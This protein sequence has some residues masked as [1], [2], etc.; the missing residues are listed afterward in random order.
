MSSIRIN[1][2]PGGSDN[3]LNVKLDQKFDF[4]EILS[5]KI[6]QEEVYRKFC[7][8]Y[9]VVVG[10]VTV[11]NGF[12]VPNAKVSIF[13]PVDDIDKENSEIFGLYP[14]EQV[15]DKNE[16]AYRYNLLPKKNETNNDCFTPIGSFFNKREVQ[17]N[18]EALEIYCKYYKFTTTTNNSGDFMIFGVPT[19]PNQLHIDAD[20]SN[21]GIISQAP[22]DLIRDGS[23]EKLFQSVS[24]FKESE[25]LDTLTQ[26]KTKSPISVNVIPFWGDLEQCE[27]GITRTDVNLGVNIVPTSI[28]IG[29]IFSD[30]DKGGIN[31]KCVPRGKMGEMDKL[32]TGPGTIE[33]IRKLPDGSTE[34]Y[35]VEGGQV[36]DENGAWA[37][38][39]PMNLDYITTDE[40]GNI[41]PTDDPNRGIPTR[42]RVRFRIGMFD[43]GGEGRLRARAKFLVPHNPANLTEVDWNFS[44]KTEDFSF[45]DMYWNKIYT[46]ANHIPSYSR[47]SFSPNSYIAI[48]DIENGQNTPFPFNRVDLTNNPGLFLFAI[49][50]QI[51]QIFI[52][53]VIFV[54]LLVTFLNGIVQFLNAIGEFF[55]GDNLI[56][57]VKYITL[58]CNGD[59][60]CVGCCQSCP[61][62]NV[63]EP[64][65]IQD[66]TGQKWLNCVTINLAL[67]LNLIKFN[68]LNDWINGTLYAMLFKIKRKKRGSGK[69]KFCEW[70]CSLDNDGDGN[71][72][73]PC[74]SA[75]YFDTCS[76]AP[77]QNQ[78][79]SSSIGN[80]T[81][82]GGIIKKNEEED[83]YYYAPI[84]SNGQV[85]FLAT[86]IINLGSVFDCDWQ[87]LPKFY[88]YLIDTT[89]NPPN[90][91]PIYYDSTDPDYPSQLEESGYDNVNGP[92]LIAKVACGVGVITSFINVG[93]DQCNNI[94]RMCELGM[95]IDEDRRDVGG[96]QA[97]DAKI[98]NDDIENPWIRGLFTYLNYPTS[99]NT[100][101]LVFIDNGLTQ[102]TYTAPYYKEF[103]GYDH[104]IADNPTI[105]QF[106]NSYY[107][108]FGLKPGASALQKLY[109]KYLPNC[110]RVV[111]NDLKIIIDDVIN[112][113]ISGIGTGSIS[114]H[115]EGGIGPYTYQWLGPTY[116]DYQY[117]CPDPDNYLDSSDCGNPD[118]G[119]S[120]NPF[121]ITDLL[122]G[123]Y[124][125]IVTDSN[126]N[127]TTTTVNL[128]GLN[129]V[130]C[131]VQP[132]PV[133]ASGNGKV[134]VSIN[135]GV[136][137]YT[138]EI[139]GVTNTAYNIVLNTAQQNYCYGNCTGPTDLPNVLNQLPAG[140]YIVTVTDSGVQ[141]IINGESTTIYTECVKSLLISQPQNITLSVQTADANCN[142]NYGEG[143]VNI[144]GGV[145][146]YDIEWLLVSSNNLDYQNLV[147][148]IISNSIQPANLVAGNYAITITDLAGNVQSTTAVIYE[149]PQVT[150]LV[151]NINAPGCYFSETGGAQVT[152]NGQNPPYNIE[153]I[154]DTSLIITNAPN[155]LTNINTLLAS[156]TPY[157]MKVTDANGCEIIEQFTVPYPQYGE[158]YVR[159][160]SKSYFDGGVDKSRIIVSFKGGNGGPY[161]F[162]LPNGNWISLGNPYTTTLPVI[163]YSNTLSTDYQLYQS[164][165]SVGGEDTFEFQFWVSDT[166]V[167]TFYPFNF[168]YYLTE[169]GQQ[170]VYAM[171]RGKLQ[172]QS[173]GT[174]GLGTYDSQQG[175]QA[176]YGC[177]TFDNIS[178][179][180]VLGQAPQGTQISQP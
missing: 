112:D 71:N 19:G 133:D 83:E 9:G 59:K 12:G 42:A 70:G 104:L 178:N 114:F 69:E 36:I 53:I 31:K 68:F 107:F 121:T 51:F 99:I 141:A 61:G 56:P 131:E 105:W 48:K 110:K 102:Y 168:E 78:T 66:A 96:G 146:P 108:Y 45:D 161:H 1:T 77:P 34:R 87:G 28:F 89:Y 124:T 4:V 88:P 162:R 136:S 140:Q 79:I 40:Y 81:I 22:Y 125:L 111:E 43:S 50:C 94:R 154:G 157:E 27:I 153:V 93:D 156:Q 109:T 95:G 173:D 138:I 15:F 118:G 116:G 97:P 113:N 76:S 145:A 132:T 33:M 163:D 14:Y 180:P 54:N 6:T 142:G 72:D 137:P 52:V 165:T 101:P 5:L 174:I 115:I 144:I 149:P 167:A 64:E 39:I 130:Q 155:G 120:D 8:D 49:L 25:N 100:I 13:I 91:T 62:F 58:N 29:S 85:K 127:Q 10:R 65:K 18:D 166:G 151:N 35:D 170:D 126:G 175:T 55:G 106:D 152:I 47:T 17:D 123:S 32:I 171:Y 60:Y 37:Y 67:G 143:L 80:S 103:R 119:T 117:K 16:D 44:E 90:E 92:A 128:S 164:T 129:S 24:K 30:N 11:N 46:V 172:L 21:I 134:K 139:Q 74:W 75:S 82:S 176:P 41:V 177:Y 158:L 160:F 169:K 3:Y 135:G 84:E 26:L 73:N 122:G 7:S 148:T 23:N 179:T 147:N 2:T 20:L 150:V 86:K 159:A 98:L 38:Q 57:Y 63:G